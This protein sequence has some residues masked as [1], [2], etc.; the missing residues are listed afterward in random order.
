[1]PTASSRVPA[2]GGPA[3]RSPLQGQCLQTQLLPVIPIPPQ[4][5]GP[6]TPLFTQGGQPG[7]EKDTEGLTNWRLMQW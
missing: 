4:L 2:A 7:K 3:S 6:S 5:G 1:M